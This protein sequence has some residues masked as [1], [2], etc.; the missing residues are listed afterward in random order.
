MTAV[1]APSCETEP[2][3]Q[4]PEARVL[5][6]AP[7]EGP[8]AGCGSGLPVTAG[9]LPRP[10][11]ELT[12]PGPLRQ[13]G[14]R[15]RTGGVREG[16]QGPPAPRGPGGGAGWTV[17]GAPGLLNSARVHTQA[18]LQLGR[19]L[20]RALRRVRPWAGCQLDRVLGG[21][22]SARPSRRWILGPKVALRHAPRPVLSRLP[23]RWAGGALSWGRLDRGFP[24]PDVHLR[25]ASSSFHMLSRVPDE[26]LQ[27]WAAQQRPPLPAG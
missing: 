26:Q 17:S 13:D 11:R 27:P 15:H 1:P 7:P 20:W 12:G 10:P 19:G 16:G 21:G 23:A 18:R 22:S 3:P 4:P 9:A 2:T 24:R 6:W 14:T 25:A 8:A 5:P